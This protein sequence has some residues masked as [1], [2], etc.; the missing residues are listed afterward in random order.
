MH[1]ADRGWG[2]LLDHLADTGPSS[3]ED[4]RTELG[5]T[6]Q[7]LRSLRS[8]LERCGAL[9]S[10]SVLVTAGEGHLH[11]SELARWDH[12][13]RGASAAGAGPGTAEPG[14]DPGR[15][16]RDLVTAGV[17]AAVIAPER[18]LRRWFSWSWYWT[19][20]LVDELVDEGR[21]RRVESQVTAVG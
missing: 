9:V 5:L 12:V 19:E 17:R 4:L 16:L 20:T 10:R 15:A 14:A 11:S 6:R 18:E 7:V 8:P 21:L 2:R 13:Y 3:I 1:A